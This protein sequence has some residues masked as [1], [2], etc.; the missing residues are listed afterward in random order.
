MR[1]L[2][3]T[4]TRAKR[5]H[6]ARLKTCNRLRVKETF[7]AALG[8]LAVAGI[9]RDVGD[10]A[11]IEN[12]LPIVGGITAAIEV[13]ISASEVQT[14]LFGYLFQCFQALGEQDHICGIDGCDGHRSSHIAVV[15]RDGD[16]LLPR[17][18][19]VPRVPHPVAPFLA[20]V[21]VPSPGST[22]RSRCFSTARCRTLARNARHSDPSWA[23]F[24]KAR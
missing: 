18:V 3:W 2:F 4:S 17:L 8:A 1:P 11:G 15:V 16:D 24:A 12:A 5:A 6:T 7:A 21:L 9:L 22:L 20:T 23:H 13:E 19:F 14:N 10:H